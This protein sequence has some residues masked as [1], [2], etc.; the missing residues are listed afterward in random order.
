M[1][2]GNHLS[3]IISALPAKKNILEI[4]NELNRLGINIGAA[5]KKFALLD[6]EQK[7][8]EWTLR[9]SPHYFNTHEEIDILV[10]SIHCLNP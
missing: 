2:Q 10:D 1:D 8:I 6:F 5:Q 3:N 9:I 7:P 4:K